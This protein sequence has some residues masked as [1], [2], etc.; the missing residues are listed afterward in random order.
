[1]IRGQADCDT[2]TGTFSF[3]LETIIFKPF[4]NLK[5]INNGNR[6][7]MFCGHLV[8]YLVCS[9][10]VTETPLNLFRSKSQNVQTVQHIVTHTE[11]C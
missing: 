1:M 10:G 9:T 6:A 2:W 7:N 3:L 4:M 5:P 11:N 8:V